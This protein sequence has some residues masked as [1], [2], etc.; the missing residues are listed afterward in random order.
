MVL[1]S[2]RG[3]TMVEYILLLA[4]VISLVTT[5]YRSA[6]Y[7]RLFGKN[8]MIGETMK[9]KTEFAYRHAFATDRR[10]GGQTADISKTNRSINVHPSYV[11]PG[12]GITRFFTSSEAYPK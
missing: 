11:E 4:V 2:Q 12:A 5:F 1:K 7:N 9:T 3:Q 8:G 6:L 10:N